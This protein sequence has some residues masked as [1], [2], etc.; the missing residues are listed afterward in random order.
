MPNPEGRPTSYRP[1]YC[2][3]VIELGKRGKSITQIACTLQVDKTTVYEWVKVHPEFSHALSR[4]RQEAQG[5]YEDIGQ[6]GIFAEG[7][8]A[9]TWAKQVSCRFPDDYRDT[10]NV[11]QNV[12]VL[13]ET[14]ALI[15][16]Q[17][18]GLPKR[19]D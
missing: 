6:T 13:S 4:A 16:G 15:D 12:N 18:A 2:E 3:Q 5:W 17:T 1:E 9:S 19:Q 14:L 11:N 8:N 10:S 7:F